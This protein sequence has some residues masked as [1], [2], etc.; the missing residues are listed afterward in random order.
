MSNWTDGNGLSVKRWLCTE[1]FVS[2]TL[3]TA[4]AVS[5]RSA[6]TDT[7][8]A[9]PSSSADGETADGVSVRRGFPSDVDQQ[10]E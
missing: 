8:H 7:W 6:V 3:W 2:L 9:T 4:S 10:R 5:V 1:K